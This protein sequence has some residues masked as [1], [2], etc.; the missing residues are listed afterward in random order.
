MLDGTAV[1]VQLGHERGELVV[2]DRPGAGPEPVF[3]ARC[4]GRPEVPGCG[5]VVQRLEPFA[6]LL[7]L[8]RALND[9]RGQVLAV[10]LFGCHAVVS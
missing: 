1:A 4:D 3:E 6:D 5:R 9:Q 10:Q 2:A 7:R 8:L